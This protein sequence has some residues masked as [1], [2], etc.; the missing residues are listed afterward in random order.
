MKIINA[1][2][3]YTP[4]GYLQNQAVAFT[5]LIKDIGP[6][7]ELIQRY[8]DAEIIQTDPHSILYPGFIIIKYCNYF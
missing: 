6:L 2:F 8:P 3:L 1:D 4:D 7:E 5:E